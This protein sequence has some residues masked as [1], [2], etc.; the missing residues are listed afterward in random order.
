MF[1]IALSMAAD[2]GVSFMPFVIAMM[3]GT[4]Y[5]FLN[6]AGYQT[7]LMVYEPGGYKFGDYGRLGLPLTVLVGIV[8][9][10]IT[11]IVFPFYP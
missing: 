3:L 5:A 11:P 1:P 8:V 10:L 9:L 7:N 2:L 4:S 6:P